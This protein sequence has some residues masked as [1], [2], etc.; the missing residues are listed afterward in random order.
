MRNRSL[1]LET[2]L[3]ERLVDTHTHL[4]ALD[5]AIAAFPGGFECAAFE[6]A[7]LG[8]ADERLTT[9]PIQAG[10]E[11]AING[12]VRIAQDLCEL[13]SWTEANRQPASVEALRQLREHGIVDGRTHTALKGAYERR[14][15]V[16]HDDIRV[17]ARDVFE[18]TLQIV[19]HAPNLLQDVALHLRQRR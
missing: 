5:R 2:E 14:N 16:Q 18:T 3:K 6:R 4:E 19:E 9:Y 17:A 15:Q 10:S 13:N 7:W 8:N 12:C 1:I 11:N